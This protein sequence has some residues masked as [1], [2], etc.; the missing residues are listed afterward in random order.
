[1]HDRER[2]AEINRLRMLTQ[3]QLAERDWNAPLQ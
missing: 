2:L 3:A 1:V